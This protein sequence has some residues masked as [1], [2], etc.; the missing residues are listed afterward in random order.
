MRHLA[1]KFFLYVVSLR[2]LRGF[3]E[4]TIDIDYE[5]S[6]DVDLLVAG[7]YLDAQDNS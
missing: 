3:P 6:G 4:L 1:D 5:K 2:F 7:V